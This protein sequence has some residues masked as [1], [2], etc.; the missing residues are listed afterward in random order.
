MKGAAKITT[1]E[2]PYMNK[3]TLHYVEMPFLLSYSFSEKLQGQF[4][5][6][7]AY[8]WWGTRNTGEGLE[9]LDY[10]INKYDISAIVGFSYFS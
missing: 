8:L 10:Q 3:T 7:V 1:T 4:G 9:E 5:P 6:A 2:D